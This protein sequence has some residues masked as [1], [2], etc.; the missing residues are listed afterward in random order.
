MLKHMFLLVLFHWILWVTYII[1]ELLFS[2]Y[3][4][5][6]DKVI[7]PAIDAKLSFFHEH[8]DEELQFDKLRC[9][10]EGI[11]SAG[12]SSSSTECYMQLR[13]LAEQ[14]MYTILNHFENEEAQVNISVFL[15]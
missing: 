9:L 10:I 7:F 11:Q 5:A 14:I 1:N 15:K 8:A 6:E 4:I 13:S 2:D 3:S 12:S